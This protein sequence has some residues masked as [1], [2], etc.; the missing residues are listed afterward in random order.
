MFTFFFGFYALANFLLFV[1][2]RSG[3]FVLLTGYSAFAWWWGVVISWGGKSGIR[4]W[5]AKETGHAGILMLLL[6]AP[7]AI[8]LIAVSWSAIASQDLLIIATFAISIAASIAF[9]R[10]Y[11]TRLPK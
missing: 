11:H 8:I 6:S 5:E 3:D 9:V 1:F 4:N 10:G 2:N 7:M